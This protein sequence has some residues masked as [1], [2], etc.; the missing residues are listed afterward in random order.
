MTDNKPP[1]WFWIISIV[2]LLWAFGGA[3]I[4]VA[5]FVETPGE[6]AQTAET[7]ANRQAYAEYIANIPAWAITAGI[8]AAL[9]RLLGAICLLL[10][11]AW[12]LPLYVISLASFL[13][14]I[15]RAFV[16]A[17][18]ARVMSGQH[19][20]VEVVFVALSVFGVGFARHNKSRGIL[21]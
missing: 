5:Y 15:Y 17:D 20:A 7:A 10:R 9:T 3:S 1:I 11:R 19:I 16:I 13:V 18:V 2:L 8:I 4:Y 21:K 6:F 12:A 14:A